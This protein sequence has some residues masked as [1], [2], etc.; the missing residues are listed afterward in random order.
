MEIRDQKTQFS[1]STESTRERP[2]ARLRREMLS[3]SRTPRQ[4]TDSRAIHFI[5]AS[6]SY[7]D[8]VSTNN[9]TELA[10]QGD[11]QLV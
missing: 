7:C 11:H 5:E 9:Q 3:G 1:E 6:P 4:S 8:D 2:S 10:H